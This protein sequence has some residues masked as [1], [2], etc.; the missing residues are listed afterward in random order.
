MGSDQKKCRSGYARL[1]TD[2]TAASIAARCI[3]FQECQGILSVLTYFPFTPAILFQNEEAFLMRLLNAQVP[4][5]SPLHS[6][7]MMALSTLQSNPDW[8][9]AEKKKFIEL[10]QAFHQSGD[11]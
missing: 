2:R 6:H 7:M 8:A 9:F 4:K 10:A 1:R 5:E 3:P 11:V